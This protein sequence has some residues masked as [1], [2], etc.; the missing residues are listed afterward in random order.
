MRKFAFIAAVSVV[1]SAA[2]ATEILKKEPP[3]GQLRPND[4]IY[5]DDGKR[6]KG[7]VDKVSGGALG[8]GGKS[9]RGA[10]AA[11]TRTCVP[12]P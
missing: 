7:Q 12:R 5:V 8:G 1:A 10:A 4:I 2:G 11:R 3:V 9:H 6:P